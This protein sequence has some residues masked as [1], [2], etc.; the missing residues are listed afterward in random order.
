[1]SASASASSL[2]PIPLCMERMD[3]AVLAVCY[4]IEAR[5]C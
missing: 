3:L 4:A 1:M 5:V 2:T